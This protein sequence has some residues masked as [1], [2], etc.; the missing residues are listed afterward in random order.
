[1]AGEAEVVQQIPESGSGRLHALFAAG[2]RESRAKPLNPRG[3]VRLVPPVRNDELRNARKQRL[4]RGSGSTLM[5]DHG[6]VR[7]DLGVGRVGQ[8]ERTL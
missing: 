7:K 2:E 3:I 6:C 4:R 5:D 8:C 1:M